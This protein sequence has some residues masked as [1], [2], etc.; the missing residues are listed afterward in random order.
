MPE[1]H[2][3][4]PWSYVWEPKG[5]TI[6]A[7]GAPM[8]QVYVA[9]LIGDPND[10]MEA[11]ARLIAAAPDLLNALQWFMDWTEKHRLNVAECIDGVPRECPIVLIARDV[12]ARA[13][14][15]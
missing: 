10:R 2:A 3:P 8:G 4:G 14:G 11:N 13:T 9:T 7:P 12:I 1:Q 5:F 15:K 6:D